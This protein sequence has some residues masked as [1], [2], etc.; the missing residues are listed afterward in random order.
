M[1]IEHLSPLP[2]SCSLLGEGKLLPAPIQCHIVNPV[3]GYR[4]DSDPSYSDP[5]PPP[6]LLALVPFL[7]QGLL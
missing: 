1:S 4:L 6:I 7:C 2:H 3:T 5:S